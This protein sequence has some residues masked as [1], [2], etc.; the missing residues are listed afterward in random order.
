MSEAIDKIQSLLKAAAD[1]RKAYKTAM[2]DGKFDWW[3]GT[4]FF[5]ILSQIPSIAKT[6]PEMLDELKTASH[7]N[8]Q[9]LRDYTLALGIAEGDVDDFIA[10]VIDSAFSVTR[11]VTG[12]KKL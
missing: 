2:E 11:V 9:E 6:A 12:F 10:D 8:R 3:E 5:P 4:S 1:A 7:E